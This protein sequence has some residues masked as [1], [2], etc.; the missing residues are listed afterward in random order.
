MT[1]VGT[2]PD[3]DS[4]GYDTP[5]ISSEDLIQELARCTCEGLAGFEALPE[6][7][8]C[9]DLAGYHRVAIEIPVGAKLADQLLNGNTGYRAHYSV[10]VSSGEQ[11]NKLLVSAIAPLVEIEESLYSDKFSRHFCRASLQG[12][13]SKFWYSK[14]TT[15]PSQQDGLMALDEVIRVCRWRNYWADKSQ[16]RKGI[17][18]PK[19]ESIL[20]NGTFV[21]EDY[22]TE[23]EQKPE[24]S[25]ELFR[26]GWV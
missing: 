10:S 12:S 23:Y 3:Q 24:R 14:S 21:A 22:T 8:S 20:F 11:F 5:P 19:C 7:E 16:P 9:N 15:D 4:W 6:Y 25:K 13:H 26:K 2:L 17:L 18:A 1:P